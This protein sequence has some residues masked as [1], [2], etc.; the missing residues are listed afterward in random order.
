MHGFSRPSVLVTLWIGVLAVLGGTSQA[1]ASADNED[2]T[3]EAAA[4]QRG[5][6]RDPDFLFGPP[7]RWVGVRGSW[8]FARADSEIFD[9]TRDLLTIEK[10]DFDAPVVAFD[11]GLVIKPQLDAVFAVEFSRASVVS[12]YREF[13]DENDVPIA[14]E[15]RLTQ[16]Q[17]SGS[18]KTYLSSRG[19]AVSQYAWIPSAVTPYVGGGGG[20]LWY[21]F[22]QS[23]DFVDFVDLS[24]FADTFE[25]NR[26]TLGAHVFGGTDVKLSRRLFLTMEAR[27]RWADAGL[28]RDFV[29]FDP[30]DL[31]GLKVT[32]GVFVVF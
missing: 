27:Y 30:I 28:E 21:K 8:L 19:R 1:S 29:G 32:A 24:I 13:V 14:Q 11:L 26:W 5:G 15:T 16:V 22:A 4:P 31:T 2:E 20:F 10:N 25:S 7:R 12:E 3:I 23:G 9:F 6:R 17:L 18:L